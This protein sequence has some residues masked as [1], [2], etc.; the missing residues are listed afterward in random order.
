MRFTKILEV[1]IVALPASATPIEIEA[2]TTIKGFD[3]SNFQTRVGFAGAFR[4]GLR[5]VLIKATEGTIFIDPQLS[6]Q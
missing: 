5:F 4:D 2:R 1:S 3:I 6:S